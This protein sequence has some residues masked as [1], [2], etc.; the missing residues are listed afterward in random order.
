ML[1]MMIIHYLVIYKH[2]VQYIELFIIQL[3]IIYYTIIYYLLY[4]Y[5]LYNYLLF[6]IQLFIIQLFCII[7]LFDKRVR[8]KINNIRV[9]LNH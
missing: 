9:I 5:L 2:T 4:N 7:N 1:I 8:E 3:F 6:I